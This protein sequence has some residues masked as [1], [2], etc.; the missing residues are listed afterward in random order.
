MSR[1]I[2]LLEELCAIHQQ[3]AKDA[4]QLD[5]DK[6]HQ[7]EG[8]IEKNLAELKTIELAGLPEEEREK[9]IRLIEETLALQNKISGRVLPWM[10]Q[11]KPLLDSFYKKP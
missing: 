8:A 5:W 2:T 4:E 3:M 6:I 7:G 1:A 10:E 11:V 9:I